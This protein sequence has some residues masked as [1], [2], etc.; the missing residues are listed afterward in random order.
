MSALLD[1]FVR[2]PMK[3]ASMTVK[4]LR[5]AVPLCCLLTAAT[6]LA[7]PGHGSAPPESVSHYVAEPVHV[8]PLAIVAIAVIGAVGAFERHRRRR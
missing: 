2:W 3:L 1:R 6:A 4:L 7:H 5:V 8:W